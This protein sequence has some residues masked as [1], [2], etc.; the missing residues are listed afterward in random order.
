MVGDLIGLGEKKFL[1]TQQKKVS[2]ELE[3]Q[4]G[5]LM[6]RTVPYVQ[7]KIKN[8]DTLYVH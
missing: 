2:G 8:D 3:G 1:V 4:L 5:K 6:N 7:E